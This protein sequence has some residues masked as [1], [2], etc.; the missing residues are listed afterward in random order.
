MAGNTKQK[1]EVWYSRWLEDNVVPEGAS[2]CEQ[3]LLGRDYESDQQSEKHTELYAG[4]SRNY[5]Q[6]INK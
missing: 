2:S 3:W 6:Q 4:R 5:Y 1:F